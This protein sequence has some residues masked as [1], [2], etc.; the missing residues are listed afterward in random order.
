MDGKCE[1][2]I[3]LGRPFLAIARTMINVQKAELTLHARKEFDVH[4]ALNFSSS[5]DCMRMDVIKYAIQEFV[6]FDMEDL[7]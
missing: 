5:N 7:L 2:P 1:V 6:E 4:R 3:I